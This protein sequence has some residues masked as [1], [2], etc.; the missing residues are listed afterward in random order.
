LILYLLPFH[1]GL[2]IF[3]VFHFFLAGLFTY[4]L[5]RDFGV[6]RAGALCG[7]V[8]FTFSGYLL[9]VV[10]MLT[11]LTSAAWIPLIFLFFN[12]ALNQERLK[13]TIL[14]GVLIGIQFL[15]G[16][17]TVLYATL[18]ALLLFA[19]A[20]GVGK[21]GSL[22]E[23]LHSLLTTNYSLL[24]ACVIGLGLTLFQALPFLEMVLHSTRIKGMGYQIASHWSLGPHELFSL[25]TPF[26][27][28]YGIYRPINFTFLQAWLKSLYMGIIPLLLAIFSLFYTRR[29]VVV[30][31]WGL[32]LGF[33]ILSFGA[34]MPWYPLLYR[35]LPLLYLIRY[36]VKFF[37]ISTFGL[38]LLAGFGI[39]SLIT[40]IKEGRVSWIKSLILFNIL[41]WIGWILGYVW[42]GDILKR[43]VATYFQD[44]TAETIGGIAYG[45]CQY[46]EN[47]YFVA[48]ILSIAI[49]SLWLSIRRR[50]RVGLLRIILMGCIIID[51]FYFGMGLNP[52][53]SKDF[54]TSL[55]KTLKVVRGMDRVMVTPKTYEYYRYLRG[56]TLREGLDGAKEAIIPNLG[57]RYHL[58][59]FGGYT[60]LVLNGHMGF[61]KEV[62]LSS[63]E[64]ARPLLSMAN[65]RYLITKWEIDDRRV[66]EVYRGGVRVYENLDLLPRTFF[67]PNILVIKKREEILKRL[68]EKG[69]DPK[70]DLILEE[71]V[72]YN[73]GGGG[74]C[75]IIEYEPNRVRIEVSCDGPSF[76]FLSDTYYPG[77]EAYIDGVRTHIYRA[78]YCFRA[79]RVPSG[80]HIVKFVYKPLSFRV[81]MIGSILSFLGIV[82]FM[83]WRRKRE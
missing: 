82:A 7:G 53:V 9:S 66:R 33:I 68:F 1:F 15:G 74:E 44:P 30:F 51:L 37:C 65:V 63:F 26:P 2:K 54:Y 71:D 31:F 19:L 49:L 48:S 62:S 46:M 77:W 11:S 56:Q 21:A 83:V 64:D 50:L 78:N 41:Y 42:S 27:S 17:P 59:A 76:L 13:Y 55:P 25:F 5:L 80:E 36:P 40:A 58:F 34:H 20:K 81:G 22:R 39:D 45:Y 57:L 52:L 23:R 43:I 10:D 12:R 8:T 28:I 3:V 60:S 75:K 32:L 47:V 24:S 18:I 69:F 67:V 29:R 38:S 70:R 72:G 6:G 4:L 79:V 35:Y 16:E 61:K 73:G 14:T